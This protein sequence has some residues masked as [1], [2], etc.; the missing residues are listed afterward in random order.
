MT[1]RVIYDSKQYKF[2]CALGVHYEDQIDVLNQVLKHY[3]EMRFVDWDKEGEKSRK[4]TEKEQAEF[5]K[6]CEEDAKRQREEREGKKR[7]GR[8]GRKKQQKK[9][10]ERVFGDYKKFQTAGIISIRANIKLQQIM[11]EKFGVPY[12]MT[13]H[14]TQAPLS[15]RIFFLLSYF[16]SSD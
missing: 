15:F 3:Q 14:T 4:I 5:R 2:G 10:Q 6:E 11:A 1:S 8:R 9:K 16:S 7:K 13:G 12:L